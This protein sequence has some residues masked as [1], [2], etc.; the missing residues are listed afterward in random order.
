M[1]PQLTDD[2]TAR[3]RSLYKRGKTA[4]VACKA[5]PR[6][7]YM[8]YVPEIDPA[9]PPPAL[10]VSM[11]GTA[12]Q[13]ELYRTSFAEFGQYNNCVVLAPLFPIGVRG[14]DNSDGYKYILE[15]D[16]R[17]DEVL[18]AMVAEV[19]AALGVSFPR[20]MLFGFSGGG[21][22]THRFLFLHADRLSAACIGS[23]GSVT[24]L[25]DSRDWWVG[26]R[27][28]KEMFGLEVDYDAL[29]RVD[30]HLVVGAADLETWEI[31][32]QPGSQ[33][34]MEG[35]NDAGATRI[36]RNTALMNSLK[37]HGVQATQSIAPNVSHSMTGVL[38][39]VKDFFLAHLQRQRARKAA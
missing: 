19:E 39:Y 14:D 27:N 31:T 35:A 21:H 20:F 17:Y 30:V 16:I 33:H 4:S 6:F 25:D 5:D 23:P 13:Q 9:G 32:H 12:R 28:V 34:W 22:F 11:H 1:L 37:A 24:L 10:L 3:R 8:L 26:I 38:P 18:L 2:A 15:G 36:E 7:S 29:A